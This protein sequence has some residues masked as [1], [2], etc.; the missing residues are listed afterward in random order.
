MTIECHF[1]ELDARKNFD[2]N[3]TYYIQSITPVQQMPSPERNKKRAAPADRPLTR[4][5]SLER[6]RNRYDTARYQ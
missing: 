4:R 1:S 2:K 3:I 5:K 6:V